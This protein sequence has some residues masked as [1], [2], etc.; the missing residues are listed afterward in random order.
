MEKVKKKMV[1]TRIFS[2][3][4]NFFQK[5]FSSES[6]KLVIERYRVHYKKFSFISM[7]SVQSKE[8]STETFHNFLMCLEYF[9]KNFFVESDASLFLTLVSWLG[10]FMI[11]FIEPSPCV[12]GA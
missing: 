8:V 9:T 2:F 1:V 3:S 5:A 4:H 10:T 7:R 6:Y 12:K 11:W